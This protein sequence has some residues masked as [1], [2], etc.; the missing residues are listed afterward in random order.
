[1]RGYDLRGTV[2]PFSIN[3]TSK[4][5]FF[6]APTLNVK[7]DLYKQADELLHPPAPLT[8]L[9]M[10][11]ASGGLITAQGE[12]VEFSAVK[13]VKSGK[14][15]V[16]LKNI[17]LKEDGFTM[18]VCLWREAAIYN[19]N[20]GD[21]ITLSHLKQSQ[22]SYGIQLQ[23]TALT[24]IEFSGLNVA[25]AVSTDLSRR[26]LMVIFG[27]AITDMPNQ[28]EVLLEDGKSLYIQSELWS[29]FDKELEE[30][31]IKYR[32]W[33]VDSVQTCG[34]DDYGRVVRELLLVAVWGGD[35]EVC[36][37]AG[38]EKQIQHSSL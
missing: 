30:A 17:Q 31:A 25:D 37:L 32:Q 38:E 8:A 35:G 1:M 26:G 10:S 11:S 27:V 18:T 24:K 14:Q 22:S 13:Q 29:P 2:P 5:Q 36:S 23:S 7:E 28:L 15:Y 9:Q 4:T 19:F 12:V 34:D 6:R 21:H 33:T 20:V 3:V 16:P